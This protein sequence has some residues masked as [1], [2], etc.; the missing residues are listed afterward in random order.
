MLIIDHKG[1]GVIFKIEVDL[2][3]FFCERGT[4]TFFVWL[5]R[6][7]QKMVNFDFLLF[8]HQLKEVRL[9]IR[10]FMLMVDHRKHILPVQVTLRFI[11]YLLL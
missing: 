9:L 11:D 3:V 1:S 6:I 4:M 2:V 5:L 10:P 8:I 7:C